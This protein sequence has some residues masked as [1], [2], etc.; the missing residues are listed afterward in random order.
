[1]KKVFIL[2]GGVIVLLVAM[3][4]IAP[5]FI[6][7]NA[8]KGEITRA[9]ET[10]TGRRLSIDGDLRFTVLP[11]PALRASGVRLSNIDGAQ[12][13]DMLT[14]KE[15]RIRVSI[16]ELFRKRIAVESI[17][18]V[19]PVITLEVLA[20]GRA[21]WDLAIN[22]GGDDTKS[23]LKSTGDAGV[24]ISLAS[25]TITKGVVSYRNGAQLEH[26]E[27]I[28]AEIAAGSLDGPFTATLS[29][30]VRGAP[31]EATLRTNTVRSNQP[32]GINSAVAITGLKSRV[33]F[34]GKLVDPGP[35]ALLK[36]KLTVEGENAASAFQRLTGS[37]APAVLAQPF[38][39][40]GVVSTDGK[41]TALND[42]AMRL[43]DA[44]A[45]GAINLN[46][47]AAIDLDV[48]LSV[49]KIELEKY[50]PAEKTREM[51]G[52]TIRSIPVKV[53]ALN[54]A[55]FALPENINASL[56]LTV[57]VLQYNRGVVRQA[58]LRATMS[59]GSITLDRASALLP[60]GSDVSAFGFLQ[61]VDDAPLFEGEVAAASDNLRAVLD[62]LNIDTNGVSTDRLR[63]FSYA[64]KVKATLESVEIQDINIRLDASIMTGA[65]ALAIRERPGLGL[66]LA[67][68]RFNLDAYLPKTRRNIAT[69]S[70]KLGVVEKSASASGSGG[71]ALLDTFD[72]NFDMR[73]ERLTFQGA[74][75]RK[76]MAEGLLVGGDMSLKT[77][78]V[79]DVMGV[80]G[81]LE[82]TLHGLGGTPKVDLDFDV[83]GMDL[84]RTFRWLGVKPPL[85]V[86]QLAKVSA[87]GKI[88]GS[89]DAISFKA[90][91]VAMGGE[92]AVDGALTDIQVAPKIVTEIRLHHQD[93]TKAVRMFIPDF[94]PAATNLGALVAAFRMTGTATNLDITSIDASVGPVAVKGVMSVGLTGDLPRI[95]TRLETG[96]VLADLFL[97]PRKSADTA[98]NRQRK[99]HGLSQTG[100][101]LSG[102]GADGANGRWSRELLDLSG[103]NGVDADVTLIMAGLILDRIALKKTHIQF[104][105]KD[106]RLSF[107]KF[108][109]GVWGGSVSGTGSVDSRVK[110]P[111]VTAALHVR[112]VE[113]R[114]LMA[115][116]DVPGRLSGPI[117]LEFSGSTSG[118]SEAELVEG[119]N[120]SARLGGRVQVHINKQERLAATALNIAAALFGKKVK[121]IGLAG[122]A[123]NVLFDAFGKSP[124]KLSGDLS[125]H[126]GVVSTQ[127]GRLNGVGAYASIVG[128]VDLPAWRVDSRT[129]MLQNS[130][131]APLIYLDVKGS[132]DTPSVTPGGDILLR[133]APAAA[134]TQSNP[135]RQRL[136]VILDGQG[137][138]KAKDLI[139]DL[140][141]GLGG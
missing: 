115:M 131:G 46:L 97:A 100:A 89:V 96:E 104:R 16:A 69:S 14:L 59:N 121:E 98:R 34:S 124:S 70:I 54:D 95:K 2:I 137:K 112:D 132:L 117:S 22:L 139:R 43:G 13:P 4:L 37:V 87:K 110:P 11:T 73:V 12:S 42:M 5:G 35:A 57:D 90:S 51:T 99:V 19:E 102:L 93:L 26:I 40:V 64:S 71:L 109:A 24:A 123:S 135:L 67:I 103:L 38:S 106:G 120:G 133:R 17:Q 94:K 66:R 126:K 49:N 81:K 9:A 80:S 58:G 39:I 78:R 76:L 52:K 84:A 68:D 33:L 82:G 113:S 119:F 36:G 75:L 27:N 86:R 116:A 134:S 25:L 111:A 50:L 44:T 1:M 6:D 15:V 85:T 60:G 130:G 129:S 91:G 10:A 53:V 47:G 28:N 125:I 118:V 29:A 77:L 72:A 32:I 108:N 83:V 62:W 122:G 31:I 21:S 92:Y 114:D 7:W 18:L 30:L 55:A 56:D 138:P 136:P 107:E 141:K 8:Y 79:A 88:D 65:L 23:G 45:N 61:M 140:L 127:N 105:L 41:L 101:V 74:T 128:A 63:G 3:V 20:D 48:A